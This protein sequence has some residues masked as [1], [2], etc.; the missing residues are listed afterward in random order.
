MS[1]HTHLGRENNNPTLLHLGN[2]N[3]ASDDDFKQ[4]DQK[5]GH[6]NNTIEL[7]IKN[8]TNTECLLI[9]IIK[10]KEQFVMGF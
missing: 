6:I 7:I 1:A 4:T 5:L 3:V 2:S 9:K 8:Y 10:V